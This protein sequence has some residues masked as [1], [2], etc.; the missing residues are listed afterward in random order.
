MRQTI[1][2]RLLESKQGIPHYRL[3]R[4]VEV[5]AL[6][7]HRAALNSAAGSRVSVNDLLVRAVGIS[8]AAHPAVNAHLLGDDVI[9][10]ADADIAWQRPPGC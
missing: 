2:R 5:S 1:A 6:L 9:R 3:E 10:F 8:L 7:A 4:T